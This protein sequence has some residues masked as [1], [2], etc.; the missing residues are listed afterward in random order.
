MN[1]SKHSDVLMHCLENKA[2]LPDAVVYVQFYDVG[3]REK[4]ESF[5]FL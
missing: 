5:E 3:L 4:L 1:E 2:F